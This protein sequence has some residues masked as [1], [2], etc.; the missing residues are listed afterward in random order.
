MGIEPI[1]DQAVKK[2]KTQ[3]ISAAA[4]QCMEFEELFSKSNEWL[5][6]QPFIG[7]KCVHVLRE[8]QDSYIVAN[9]RQ[10]QS[11]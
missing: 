5:L 6:A 4:R 10:T 7:P 11:K 1:S 8:I 3:L 2:C 9:A